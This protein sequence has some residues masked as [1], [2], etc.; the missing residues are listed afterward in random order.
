MKLK[1]ITIVDDAVFA[2][3]Q[4]G[5]QLDAWAANQMHDCGHEPHRAQWLALHHGHRAEGL[6][7][8]QA[9]SRHEGRGRER[10]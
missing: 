7:L 6:Q 5:A 9:R 10:I 1:W 3:I 4:D 2:T 8:R